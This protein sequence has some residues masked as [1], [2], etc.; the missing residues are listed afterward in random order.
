MDDMKAEVMGTLAEKLD[1][2][3]GKR[4]FNFLYLQI[5]R[6]HIPV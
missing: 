3:S 1:I 2:S 6:G 5:E 4:W